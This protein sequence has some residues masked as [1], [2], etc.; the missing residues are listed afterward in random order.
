M[1]TML[2]LKAHMW[3][4]VDS[5]NLITVIGE[6]LLYFPHTN[7]PTEF[8]PRPWVLK[9]SHTVFRSFL[10]T[11]VHTG[12]LMKH[13]CHRLRGG[14]LWRQR[15][16]SFSSCFGSKIMWRDCSP[17][18]QSF[19]LGFPFTDSSLS[20]T[21][22]PLPSFFYFGGNFCLSSFLMLSA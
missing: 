5:G 15:L 19:L 21:H 2:S 13:S 14:S 8:V 10:G 18:F 20:P 16:C 9:H 22:G 3:F 6:V 11:W 7:P 17:M 1:C 4:K 12:F